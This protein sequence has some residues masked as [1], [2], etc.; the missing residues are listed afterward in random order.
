M[1]RRIALGG[2][3]LALVL[4]A[5][6]PSEK[7]NESSQIVSEVET[8]DDQESADE[9]VTIE[10]LGDLPAFGRGETIKGVDGKDYFRNTGTFYNTFDTVIQITLYTDNE[11]DFERYFG[12]AQDE[13]LRLHKLYNQYDAFEGIN[14]VR[15][16]NEHAGSEPVVVD[17]DL[18]SLI[19]FA[20]DYHDATLGKVNIAMGSVLRLWHDAREHV[21]Y[22]ADGETV[23]GAGE[24]ENKGIPSAAQLEEANK[25]TDIKKV[26]LN[27]D[28]L[29]VFL[30]DEEMSLDVGAVAKGY[31]TELVAKKLHE[32]GVKFGLISAGGNIKAIGEKPLENNNWVVGI[33]HPNL[34]IETPI[35]IVQMPANQSMVT[36]GDYQRFFEVDGVKYHH[37]ID[38]LTLMPG[39]Y[40]PSVSVMVEDS[41]LADML[42]TSLF[43][44]TKEEAQE[45]VQNIEEMTDEEVEIIWIDFDYHIDA[46]DGIAGRIENMEP[47][48]HDHDHEE[49]GHDHKEEDHDHE[50]DPNH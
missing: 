41:G 21:G 6:S 35:T 31:G 3:A 47:H 11:E 19:K 2:L 32:E 13:F 20:V 26:I 30:E 25:H 39:T 9:H 42:S 8:S 18:F 4:S 45:I 10:D 40:Y 7:D 17:E 33:M 36:S 43:L 48:D 12:M 27:E 49:E 24:D 28:D 16:I 1:R 15:T 5:C 38:P 46:T 44:S 37:I 22:F 29:S 50:D 34:S 14:N 23:E